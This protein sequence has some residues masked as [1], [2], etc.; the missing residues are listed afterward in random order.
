[1]LISLGWMLFC[2]NSFNQ[3]GDE[4]YMVGERREEHG[5][6]DKLDFWQNDVRGNQDYHHHLPMIRSVKCIWGVAL[7]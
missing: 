2:Q 5:N 3:I 6:V 4:I 1:M 7:L